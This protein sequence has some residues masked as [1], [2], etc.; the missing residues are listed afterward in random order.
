M[1]YSRFWIKRGSKNHENNNERKYS[2]K[3]DSVICKGLISIEDLITGG[4]AMYFLETKNEP[5]GRNSPT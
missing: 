3:M 4:Y 2:L 1:D 5:R